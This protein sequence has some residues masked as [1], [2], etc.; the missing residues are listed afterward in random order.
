MHETITQN[1][2]GIA[3]QGRN[4]PK[5]VNR[6]IQ[7]GLKDGVRY[8][9]MPEGLNTLRK[10]DSAHKKGTLTDQQRASPTYRSHFGDRQFWHS[11]SSSAD[12]SAT[13]VKAKIMAQASEWFDAAMTKVDSNP[14]QSAREIG[15]VLHMVQDSHSESH[16]ERNANGEILG[17]QDY[18]LQ[19]GDAHGH[20]DKINDGFSDT[21]SNVEKIPGAV[22]ARD[23]SVKLIG[24]YLNRDK[25]SFMKTV[26]ANYTLAPNAYVKDSKPEYKQPEDKK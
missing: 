26:D 1:A 17:F 3:A 15:K 6:A 16:V 21:W 20:A 7:R 25:S 9:D 10:V 5:S 19:S 13:D 14:E 12:S 8:P 23:V 11:M 22:A 24:A 4:M 2:Y 18:G